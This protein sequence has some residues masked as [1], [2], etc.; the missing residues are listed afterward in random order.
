VDHVRIG[1]SLRALR[2]R[3]RLRQC[4]LATAVELSQQTISRAERGRIGGLT[5][6]TIEAIASELGA[7]V[8][9]AVRWSGEGLDRLLDQQHAALVDEIARVLRGWGWEVATEVSFSIYGERGSVDVVG[10]RASDR[11][12]LVVEAKSVVPDVQAM[13]NSIDRKQR[14]GAAIVRDRGWQPARVARLLV[15]AEHRTA[16]R[17]VDQH[18]ATFTSA[19]SLRGA[20]LRRWLRAPTSEA[21]SGLWFLSIPPGASAMRGGGARER[22]RVPREARQPERPSVGQGRQPGRLGP[23]GAVKGPRGTVEGPGLAQH[24]PHE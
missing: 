3:K 1:L 5:V 19:F 20:E 4:D 24:S 17:R 2:R 18:A 7:S 6:G 9:L 8:D 23:G 15:I 10:W 12:L 13:L 11:L 21:V 14:L 22:V 16:R